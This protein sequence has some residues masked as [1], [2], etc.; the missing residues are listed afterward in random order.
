METE[1]CLEHPELGL[2]ATGEVV[3]QTF[4]DGSLYG[5][6]DTHSHIMTNW[7]FGGGGLH[8]QQG[9]QG[10]VSQYGSLSVRKCLSFRPAIRPGLLRCI[11]RSVFAFPDA[12]LNPSE[13][14]CMRYNPLK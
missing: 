1:G 3:P 12:S 5:I 14:R 7:G 4:E 6:V 10:S 2:S 11:L 13:S 9:H 8:Q